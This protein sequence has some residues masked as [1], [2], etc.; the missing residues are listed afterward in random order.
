MTTF[1]KPRE[2][3]RQEGLRRS[4]L[5]VLEGRF[6]TLSR[7]VKERVAAIPAEQ[8]DALL[9]A[10]GKAESLQVLGLEP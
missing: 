10:A 6:G 9:V 1:E 2:E 8:L 3:G 4:L 5:L 7:V